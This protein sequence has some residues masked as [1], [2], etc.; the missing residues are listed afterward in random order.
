M[1]PKVSGA[2]KWVTHSRQ[3]CSKCGPTTA[4]RRGSEAGNSPRPVRPYPG[5]AEE[6][7]AGRRHGEA[8][9]YGARRHAYPRAP[10][11][12]PLPGKLDEFVQPGQLE[13]VSHH[14]DPGDLPVLHLKAH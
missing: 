6:A 10:L 9:R 7:S 1:P 2:A 5:P 13:R 12:Q 8:D 4:E 11:L 14:V 3:I